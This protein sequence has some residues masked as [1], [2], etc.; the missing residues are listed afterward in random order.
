MGN[1]C[2]LKSSMS[3]KGSE[4]LGLNALEQ[5]YNSVERNALRRLALGGAGDPRSGLFPRLTV[6]RKGNDHC[7]GTCHSFLV[8]QTVGEGP[9]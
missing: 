7:L 2:S 6:F 8:R 1:R 4:S 5:S 3:Q 9:S